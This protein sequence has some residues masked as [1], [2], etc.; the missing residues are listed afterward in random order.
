M[1]HLPAH[2]K[3]IF[4]FIILLVALSMAVPV[5]ADY[6][7][8]NRTVTTTTSVC[9]AVLYECKEVNGHWKYKRMQRYWPM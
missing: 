9:Q 2:S 3:W 8:P 5:L 1:Q 4:F 7:G 6:L